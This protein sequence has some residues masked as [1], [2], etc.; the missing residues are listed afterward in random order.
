MKELTTKQLQRMEKK[1][2]KMAA[3]LEIAKLNDK[4]KEAKLQALKQTSTITDR[5]SNL[6]NN[7]VM[8]ENSNHK[9]S[10][11]DLDATS[12]K[13]YKEKKDCCES[14]SQANNKK[15]RYFS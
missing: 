11:K 4:D 10:Y 8:G 13:T 15:P 14:E 9:R 5:I 3:F 7:N 1:K 12:S 2:A 6:N